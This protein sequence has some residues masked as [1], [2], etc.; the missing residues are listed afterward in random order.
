MIYKC[1]KRAEGFTLVE[2]SIVIIII[3]FLIAGIAAG[4]ALIKQAELN[5]IIT[6][7]Q[8]LATAIN[9]FQIRYGYLPG[10]FPNAESYWPATANGD[11]DGIVSYV[12]LSNTGEYRYAVNQLSLSGILALN[13]N[14]AF[15]SKY[16]S[17][18][19]WLLLSVPLNIYT[20]LAS[21]R[22][23]WSIVGE[24]PFSKILSPVDAYAVDSKVDDGNPSNGKV[25]SLDDGTGTGAVCEYQGDGVTRAVFNT[26][27]NTDAIYNLQSNDI[28]CVTLM[29]YLD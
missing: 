15:F 23:A 21:T 11:G 27:A 10:D 28:A 1:I 25:N 17:G 20:T 6:E 16:R 4:Q 8:T 26:Y 9:T 24:T 12:L 19:G 29:F 18:T 14:Q 5:S 13:P 3:G 22:N 7:H 2:L